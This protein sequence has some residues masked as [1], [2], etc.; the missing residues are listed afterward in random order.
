MRLSR[1]EGMFV[2]ITLSD[3]FYSCLINMALESPVLFNLGKN[4]PFP[5]FSLYHH[6]LLHFFVLVFIV[7]LFCLPHPLSLPLLKAEILKKKSTS[8]I[9]SRRFAI[10][11]IADMKEFTY[12]L[13]NIYTTC[14][15]LE[16]EMYAKYA[17][18]KMWAVSEGG[19]EGWS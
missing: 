7:T 16:K 2:T 10:Y 9:D 11:K 14:V 18:N 4:M 12:I 5:S 6:L 17:V 3:V 1:C 19:E 13:Q 8:Q 15:I